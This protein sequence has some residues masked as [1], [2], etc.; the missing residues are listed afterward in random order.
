MVRTLTTALERLMT[1][2]IAA[3]LLDLPLP[4][5]AGPEAVSSVLRA[6]PSIPV[7]VIGANGE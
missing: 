4:D 7:F 2:G 3:V 5:G 1:A 6:A